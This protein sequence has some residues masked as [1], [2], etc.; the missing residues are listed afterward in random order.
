[1]GVQFSTLRV[2]QLV[3]KLEAPGGWE[4]AY[5]VKGFLGKEEGR[6]A[7]PSTHVG[8]RCGTMADA[9]SELSRDR[10]VIPKANAADWRATGFMR[11]P[12]S[13]AKETE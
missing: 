11:D 2:N 9:N 4:I 5:W 1:M 3:N 10:N 8:G 7:D 13:K 12:V 6:S